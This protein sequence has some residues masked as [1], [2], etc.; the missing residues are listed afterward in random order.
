MMTKCNGRMRRARRG[1]F[2]LGLLT[3]MSIGAVAAPK[4]ASA[5]VPRTMTVQGI[6]RDASG[7]PIEAPTTFRFELLDGTTSVWT[8]QQSISPRA[9]LFTVRL[10]TETPLDPADFASSLALRITVA[11]E[12]MDPIPLTSVPYAFRAETVETYDGDVAWGQVTGVPSGF[13]DGTD[14][15]TTYAA[16]TGLTLMGSTFAVDGSA[17]QTRVAGACAVGSSIRA[18]AEDGTV[19]C[20]ADDAGS[21]GTTYTAGA[22]LT[23]MGSTFAVDGAAVQARV[24]AT[25]PPGSSIR[26]IGADGTV[27]CE[28]DDDTVTTY[29]AGDGMSLVGTTFSV[30]TAYVQR[31]VA[32]GCT[33]GSAIRSIAADGSVTCETTGATAS[34]LGDAASSAATS[35]AAIKTARPT[36]ASGAYWLR[37]STT[38]TSFQAYCDM[39]TD[40]GG[41]TLVWSNLRGGRSKPTTELDWLAAVNTLPR[42]VGTLGNDPESFL[43][44][45]GLRHWTAMS[46][47]TQLRYSWANDYGSPIDQSYRCTYGFTLPNYNLGLIS[48]SQLVGTAVPGLF[49]SHN[50]APF[51]AYNRDLDANGSTNCSASF[52]NTP[53]W[54]TGCWDGSING[55]SEF[56]SGGYFN[57][58]YWVGSA[59]AWGTDAG[60]G[61]GN[62]WIFVR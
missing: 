7:V 35:C 13:A 58:A 21:V 28:A 20:E 60:T 19:T 32:A 2:G 15:G 34:L 47:G 59:S 4:L 23:L 53:F 30:D 12:A 41:W 46:P 49:S 5:Q 33:A 9:G 52:G 54:Y 24:S 11:G 42:V 14:D 37:P 25:C 44:F 31:R 3:A 51:S 17:V 45:I 40:G 43:Y 6:L 48:C 27:T 10:G 26:A 61:A 16:G 1:W 29:S 36:A 56:S 55:G 62:G 38:T 8:E 22:G 57:G 39:T 50:N 18:I